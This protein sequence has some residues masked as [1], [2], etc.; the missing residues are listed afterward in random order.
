MAIQEVK[1]RLAKRAVMFSTGGF[2]PANTNRESWIGR[3]YLYKP[4]EQI[5]WLANNIQ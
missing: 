2:K 1:N 5:P 3:V 4:H